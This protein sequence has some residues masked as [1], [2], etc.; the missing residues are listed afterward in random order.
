MHFLST[1]SFYEST[2]IYRTYLFVSE[3]IGIDPDKEHPLPWYPPVCQV[4][5]KFDQKYI[6][7]ELVKATTGY[8]LPDSDL[9]HLLTTLVEDAEVSEIGQRILTA[10]NSV[11]IHNSQFIH[12]SSTNLL[13]ETIIIKLI[14]KIDLFFLITKVIL[15]LKN[16]F[17]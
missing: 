1:T 15:L 5:K 4:P 2:F 3:L 9:T 8:N 7:P 13:A 12:K 14:K 11:C 6:P 10:T 17:S 16:V